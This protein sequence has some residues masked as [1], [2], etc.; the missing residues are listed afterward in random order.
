MNLSEMNIK[1]FF[2][3][4]LVNVVWEWVSLSYYILI[5]FRDHKMLPSN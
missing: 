5:G 4:E 3:M 2:G 1:S